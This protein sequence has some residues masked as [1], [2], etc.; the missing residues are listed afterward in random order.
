MKEKYT[1]SFTI[2]DLEKII[3]PIDVE[4]FCPGEYGNR[5]SAFKE[6]LILGRNNGI[7]ENNG[8]VFLKKNGWCY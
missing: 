6:T 3:A 4:C 1:L 2:D 8:S 7:F 5:L